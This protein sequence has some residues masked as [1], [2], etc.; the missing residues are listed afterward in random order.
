[1]PIAFD[2]FLKKFVKSTQDAFADEKDLAFK[3][4]I[5][6]ELN[7]GTTSTP[8][9]H[10]R[11]YNW[12][13]PFSL[14]EFLKEQKISCEDKRKGIFT[15]CVVRD[16]IPPCADYSYAL[17][18]Y[19]KKLESFKKDMLEQKDICVKLINDLKK[20]NNL[21]AMVD[22]FFQ[23]D[24]RQVAEGYLSVTFAFKNADDNYKKIIGIAQETGLKVFEYSTVNND[25]YPKRYRYD[26][27]IGNAKNEAIET[28]KKSLES[29]STF[30]TQQSQDTDK[31]SLTSS[32]LQM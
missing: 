14:S 10:Y 15:F 20:I 25:G 32:R 11:I 26:V 24:A 17:Q 30:Q 3:T 29:L 2:E 8:G 21:T 23:G 7:E 5:K 18:A 28:F 16:S 31:T 12:D 22:V 4:T 9:L 19:Q 13:M 6:L 1:M 27:A